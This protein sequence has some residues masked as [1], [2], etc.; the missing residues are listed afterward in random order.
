MQKVWR[1][2]AICLLLPITLT[3]CLFGPEE[4]TSGAID[5]PPP[6]VEN[7]HTQEVQAKPEPKPV[8]DQKTEQK[9][10]SGIE[11]YFLTD[12]GYVVPYTVQMPNVKTVAKESL[13]YMVQGG[14]GE[15]LLPKGFVP[16]LPK[17]TEIKGLDIQNGTANVDFSKNFLNYEAKMEEKVLSAVTWTLTGLSSVKKVNIWV[18]GRPLA[19]M[20]KGKNQAQG[21]TKSRGINVEI[22]EGVNLTQSIPVTLYFMGQTPDNEV[23]YVPVTRMIN[24]AENIA[25]A[26]MKEL[27]RGPLQSST[28]L[29][30]ALDQS[31]AVNRVQVKGDTVLADFGEQ[32]LQYDNQQKTSKNVLDTIVFSLTE[33][34]ATKKVKITVNGKEQASTAGKKG[35]FSQPV[36]RPTSINPNGL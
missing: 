27:I 23:Y 10:T 3:G 20:P 4:K 5:P 6:H 13:K 15:A 30:G 33:N 12:H 8:V 22:A 1:T 18:D 17:G 9:K 24:R 25:Q 35:T 21:L 2:A 19:V 14:P 7:S 34:T 16:I 31:T 29:I 28:N 26:A 11:L 32:L 36:L